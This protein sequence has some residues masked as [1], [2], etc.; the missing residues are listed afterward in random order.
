[1]LLAVKKCIICILISLQNSSSTN[2]SWEERNRSLAALQPKRNTITTISEQKRNGLFF[3]RKQAYC[4]LKKENMDEAGR[5]HSFQRISYHSAAKELLP[6]REKQNGSFRTN[7]TDK[8][9]HLHKQ[10]ANLPKQAWV[11]K[12]VNITFCLYITV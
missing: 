7:A 1:M 8:S 9:V 10:Q 4:V 5:H 11:S 12:K 6:F 2:K 3:Y